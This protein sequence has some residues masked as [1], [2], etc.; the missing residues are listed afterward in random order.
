MAFEKLKD[1]WSS[2]PLNVENYGKLLLLFG[3]L[4]FNFQKRRDGFEGDQ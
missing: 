4:I 1:A 3:S 2:R